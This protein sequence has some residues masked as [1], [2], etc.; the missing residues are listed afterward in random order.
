MKLKGC[1]QSVALLVI[2]ALAVGAVVGATA[3]ALAGPEGPPPVTTAADGARAQRKLFDLATGRARAGT[4]TFSEAEVNALLGRH[5]VEARGVRLGDPAARLLGDDRVLVTAHL[6]LQ[7]LLDDAGVPGLGSVLTTRWRARPVWLRVAAHVRVDDGARRQLRLEVEHFA[8][9][10]QRLPAAAL[11][12]LLDPAAVGL[13]RWPL[14]QDV[15]S[16]VIEPGRVV[17]RAAS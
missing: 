9:G 10:R 6:P 14:P 12:L 8:L 11:R 7:Q 17:I 1:L 2:G 5:L 3:R 15:D 4:V 16:V 13:L